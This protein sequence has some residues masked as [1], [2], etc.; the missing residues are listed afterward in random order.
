[1]LAFLTEYLKYS[2]SLFYGEVSNIL[3][4]LLVVEVRVGS[5]E[6]GTVVPSEMLHTVCGYIDH[7]AFILHCFKSI[8]GNTNPLH[9][10]RTSI[11]QA[12]QQILLGPCV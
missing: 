3:G 10:A 12:T 5:H 4:L 11:E 9:R 1:M 6:C 2:L 7:A 8:V